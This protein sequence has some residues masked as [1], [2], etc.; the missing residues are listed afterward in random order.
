MTRLVHVSAPSGSYEVKIGSGLLPSIG[1][2]L[3]MDN[4]DSIKEL[5]DDCLTETRFQEGRDRAREESWARRGESAI[6]ITD[7]LL[8]KRREL[9]EQAD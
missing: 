5:I 4:V 2:E 6:A 1:Q 3:G 9:E 7:Y 8:E